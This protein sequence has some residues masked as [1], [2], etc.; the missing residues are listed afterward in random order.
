M[1]VRNRTTFN[2]ILAVAAVL[3]GCTSTDGDDPTEETEA[4]ST[5]GSSGDGD[6]TTAQPTGQADDT[7]GSSTTT[8]PSSSSSTSSDTDAT[9]A[10]TGSGD[11][12]S[13]TSGESG[14]EGI[15]GDGTLD[16]GEVCD[17]GNLDPEDA[18][19]NDCQP[20]FYTGTS[21]P[22]TAQQSAEC[23]WL[24]GECRQLLGGQGGGA[25]C[26]WPELSEDAAACD[27]SA[28]IWT[29][30]DSP[31]GENNDVSIPEPGVCITQISNLRCS[32]ADA[33]VCGGAG[34]NICFQDKDADGLGNVGP[35]LCGWPG[36]EAECQAPG[37]WTSSESTFA[38]NHPNA[39]APESMGACLSQVSNLD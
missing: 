13:T 33:S 32:A 20:Q 16:P 35:S 1:S 38:M 34:A 6:T 5:G 36:N 9:A 23:E 14:E 31:F 22:C 37:I 29:P 8:A 4:S 12:S 26:Y 27:S 21:A 24:G 25:L 28:G 30:P 10:E 19:N 17:D 18:C 7:E 3:S 15:C 39:L 2:L 11:S